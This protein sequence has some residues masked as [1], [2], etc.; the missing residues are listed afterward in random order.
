MTAFPPWRWFGERRLGLLDFLSVK[1]REKRFAE[2]LIARL[3]EQGWPNPIGFDATNYCLDLGGEAGKVSLVNIFRGWSSYPRGERAAAIDEAVAFVIELGRPP[4]SFEE[5]GPDLLPAIRSRVAVQAMFDQPLDEGAAEDAAGAWRP[6]GDHLA[7]QVVID[8]PH[9]LSFVTAQILKDWEH[10]FAEV[11][12]LALA[13]LRQKEPLAFERHEGGFYTSVG[14][15]L[16]HDARLLLPDTFASISLR[17]APVVVAASRDCLAVAG[18]DDAEALEAMAMVVTPFLDQHPRPISYAPMI[19]EDG[20][21]RAFQAPTELYAAAALQTHQTVHDYEQ[22]L[23]LILD[24][25]QRTG[26]AASVAKILL[27]PTDQGL[28]SLAL[29]VEPACLLPRADFIVLKT[30]ASATVVRAWADVEA[31]CGGFPLEPST[32]SPYHRVTAWPG[33][34]AIEKIEASPE[35]DWAQGKGVGVSNGRLTLFG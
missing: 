20:H 26:R 28:R 12:E 27:L 3:S 33:L 21:W 30:G 19:L 16:N 4:P 24:R 32:A 23:P 25:L 10:S 11:F 22:Q 1:G 17:G 2:R 18:A 34:I 13:N 9:S 6:L 35:P 7:I 14:E 8:R 31:A 15:D 5:A 29:W